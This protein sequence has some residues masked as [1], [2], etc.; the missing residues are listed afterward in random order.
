MDLGFAGGCALAANGVPACWGNNG[1]GQAAPPLPPFLRTYRQ[2]NLGAFHGCGIFDNGSAACWGYSGTSAT[3]V[4]A[5]SWLAISAGE[6]YSCGLKS[7]GTL[8]C[9]GGGMAVPPTGSFKALA[10]GS[11]HACAIRDSGELA[12][13][14]SN[15]WG[16]ANAPSGRYVHVSSGD[17]TVARSARTARGCAGARSERCGGPARLRPRRFHLAGFIR[18]E[19]SDLQAAWPDPAAPGSR[20][21]CARCSG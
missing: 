6:Q 12:C 5:G 8:A 14:G 3:S 20:R 19:R 7:N 18:P 15:A 17:S 11:S 21:W 9:W 13:W 1:N 4:P 2:V 16:Q 10:S